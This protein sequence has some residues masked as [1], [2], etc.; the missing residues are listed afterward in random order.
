MKVVKIRGN[1]VTLDLNEVEHDILLRSGLQIWIDDKIGPNKVKVLPP[2]LSL[3]PSKIRPLTKKQQK[4]EDKIV[5]EF[6]TIAVNE[7]LKQAIDRKSP[8]LCDHA[9]EVPNTCTCDEDCYCKS[10]TCKT[11]K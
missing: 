3:I 8:I 4:E 1:V 7:A 9:N 5:N 6:L 2:D 11:M 10:H